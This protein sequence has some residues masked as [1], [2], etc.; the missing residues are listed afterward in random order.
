V[1]LTVLGYPEIEGIAQQIM[2][3][4][5]E[6]GWKVASGTWHDEYLRQK[7]IQDLAPGMTPLFFKADKPSKPFLILI[8]ELKK[9]NL[10]I[11]NVSRGSG[12]GDRHFDDEYR[13]VIV[14][15]K[16]PDKK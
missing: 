1:P 9:A 14:I 4:L 16:K 6:A 8:N 3:V 7:G 15:G 10:H 13:E 11:L 12:D 5:S 2:D